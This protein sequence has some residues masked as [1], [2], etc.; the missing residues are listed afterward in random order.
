MQFKFRLKLVVGAHI[1]TNVK[2]DWRFAGANVELPSSNAVPSLSSGE[3]L[4]TLHTP[5][6]NT[7]E[8]CFE[9]P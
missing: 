1:E 5:T 3:L 9:T 8:I 4:S 7:F 2:P 6:C